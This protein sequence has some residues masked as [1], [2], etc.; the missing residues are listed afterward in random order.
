[1]S[2]PILSKEEVDRE[3]PINMETGLNRSIIEDDKRI[4]E[5]DGLNE[6]SKSNG[7]SKKDIRDS[8]I[9]FIKNQGYL[10]TEGEQEFD[11]ETNDIFGK[12]GT[13]IELAIT[14][15]IDDGVMKQ[16]IGGCA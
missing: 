11:D 6:R 10:H 3:D 4:E 1:M 2:I 12:D 15:G 9:E 5:D 13:L 16:V 14:T 8:I 7:G